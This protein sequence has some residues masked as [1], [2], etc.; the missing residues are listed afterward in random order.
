MRKLLGQG[1]VAVA[2]GATWFAALERL[3]ALAAG[4]PATLSPSAAA[5]LWSFDAVA[6][7]AVGAVGALLLPLRS[8]P[9]RHGL[10]LAALSLVATLPVGRHLASGDW[11]GAQSWAWVVVWGPAAAGFAGMALFGRLLASF[12]GSAW[13]PIAAFGLSLGCSVADHFVLPGQHSTFHVLMHALATLFLMTAAAA[14]PWSRLPRAGTVA[15]AVAA[16]ATVIVSLTTVSAATRAELVHRSPTGRR[17]LGLLGPPAPRGFIR[18]E[19]ERLGEGDRPQPARR[20]GPTAQPPKAPDGRPWSVLFVTVDTLRADALA[21]TREAGRAFAKPGDTPFMDDLAARSTTF[22]TAYAQASITHLSLPAMFRS[23]E[24]FEGDAMG[25]P[26]AMVMREQ[27]LAPAAV[28]NNFF[29]EPRLRAAHRLMEGFE[30]VEVYDFTSM[31]STVPLAAKV[32]DAVRGQRFFLWVHFYQMHKPRYAGKYLYAGKDGRLSTRY[33][34]GLKWLD[35]QMKVLLGELDQRGLG[36][37][38]ITVLASDH[39]EGLGDNSIKGHGTSIYE[40]EIRVP[41]YIHVPGLE[42]RVVEDVVG[43]VD[44]LPTL[45]DLLGAPPDPMHRGRRLTPLLLGRAEDWQPPTYYL[46]SKRRKYF[47]LVRDRDKLIHAR[48]SGAFL[49]FDL[50]ADPK[51]DLNLYASNPSADLPPVRRLLG[52]RPGLFDAELDD[53]DTRDQ[54]ARLLGEVGPATDPE[55]LEFLIRLAAVSKDPKLI[56]QGRRLFDEADDDRTK[57]MVLRRLGGADRTLR[58]KL[59][60]HLKSLAG[61]EREQPFVAGL[62]AQQQ[63]P[64]SGVA[65][66]MGQLLDTAGPEQW[67]PW[68]WLTREWKRKPAANFAPVLG[69]MLAKAGPES[70]VGRL[71]LEGLATMSRAPSEVAQHVRP[72]LKHA[73]PGV[74]AWAIGALGSVGDDS[75]APV[76]LEAMRTASP[77]ERQAAVH[78]AARVMGAEALPALIEAKA[79][80]RLTLDTVEAFKRIGTAG[81]VEPLQE[82][83]KKYPNPRIRNRANKALKVVRA[84]VRKRA[85]RAKRA[86]KGSGAPPP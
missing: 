48:K 41:L 8:H 43:N 69:G 63:G 72:W 51:E 58:G 81:C 53:D 82:V 40:E 21:P 27:G 62:A 50:R 23:T 73:V 5:L 67:A 60:A 12:S 85:K 45:L 24:A 84:K 30:H 20:P 83:A 33:R 35:G 71:A 32:L 75:D 74:R 3:L 65:F 11:I 77:R 1:A 49:R 68:L 16:C 56:A 59:S 7:A 26:L 29:L 44:V 4:A 25:R 79:D 37:S 55:D 66:R 17:M 39:G 15:I 76:I 78:A 31:S 36:Q 10:V 80:V 46:Q 9:W 52:L 38:T 6:L 28:V 2:A 19:L 13:L 54:V 64:F 57:L 86:K 42:P 47:G 18:Y 70:S 61:T 22:R 14:L 34:K